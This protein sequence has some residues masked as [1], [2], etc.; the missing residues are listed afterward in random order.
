MIRIKRVYDRASKE[1]CWR[2]LVDRLWPRG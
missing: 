1:D 2:V